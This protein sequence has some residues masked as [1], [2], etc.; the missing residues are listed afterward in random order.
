MTA[1]VEAAEAQKERLER[2]EG[3]AAALQEL[4]ERQ[5]RSHDDAIAAVCGNRGFLMWLL[6]AQIHSPLSHTTSS[7]SLYLPYM[8]FSHHVFHAP[9]PSL[10]GFLTPRLPLSCTARPLPSSS[11]SFR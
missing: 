3:E 1:R 4:V 6:H 8:A 2:I 5:R 11:P 10:Y 9:L 7:T